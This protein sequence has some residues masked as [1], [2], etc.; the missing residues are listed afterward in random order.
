MNK[1]YLKYCVISLL[2]IIFSAPGIAAY[3]FYQ[4]PKWLAAAKTNKGSLLNPPVRMEALALKNKWRIIFWTS[5]PC[6]TLCIKELDTLARVRLAL[7]RKLYE[8]DQLLILGD[9]SESLSQE[10]RSKVKELDFQVAQLSA[11]E[12]NAQAALFSKAGV[13]LADPNNYLVL[14]Y[15]SLVNPDDV[16]HD[17]KLLLNTT[18]KNG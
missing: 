15:P 5:G 10:A 6:D 4:H 1:K 17:L 11:K 18:E 16:F 2:I 12:V 7:G 9:T 14:S 13:F 8:V 3:I